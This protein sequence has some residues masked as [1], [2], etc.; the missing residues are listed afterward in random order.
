MLRHYLPQVERVVDYQDTIPKPGLDTIEGQTI[1]KLLDEQVNPQVAGHGGHIALVDVQ[2]TIVYIRLE[3]G[4]QGCGMASMTLKHG[5][6]VAIK[7]AVPSIEQVLDTTDHA[8][9]DNPYFQPGKEGM[10]AY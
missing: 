5:V 1:Q 2:D 6:E 10:S 7:E 8:G 9:G 3:G 4:C